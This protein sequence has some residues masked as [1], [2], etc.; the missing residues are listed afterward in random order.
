MLVKAELLPKFDA[1]APNCARCGEQTAQPPLALTPP[2]ELPPK[3][4]KPLPP[5]APKPPAPKPPAP[6]ARE[7]KDATSPTPLPNAVVVGATLAGADEPRKAAASG[8]LPAPAKAAASELLPKP[9]TPNWAPPPP[10]PPPPATAPKLDT[11]GAGPKPADSTLPA[12]APSTT[13]EADVAC[14]QRRN[15]ERAHL[16]Q[17]GPKQTKKT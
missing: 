1:A 8:L 13:H 9:L 16:N 14:E 11:E 17:R 2:N 7:P 4:P 12:S 6:P 3:A 5:P 10:P 15:E